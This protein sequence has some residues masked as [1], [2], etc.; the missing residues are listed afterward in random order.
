VGPSCLHKNGPKFSEK[1][2]IFPKG[3]DLA[4][5]TRAKF[6]YRAHQ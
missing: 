6:L 4:H 1:V 2:G 3:S 5:Q